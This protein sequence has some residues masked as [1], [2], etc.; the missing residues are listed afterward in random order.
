MNPAAH[1]PV[2]RLITSLTS[3]T[4]GARELP[5]RLE[6]LE[7]GW[8]AGRLP[9]PVFMSKVESRRRANPWRL[10]PNIPKRARHSIISPRPE[11]E[12]RF[13]SAAGAHPGCAGGALVYGISCAI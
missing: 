4:A 5:P 3:L 11:P 1:S 9:V 10:S 13:Q 12:P 7:N 8:F 6:R 2:F